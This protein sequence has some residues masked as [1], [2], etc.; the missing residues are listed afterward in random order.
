MAGRDLRVALEAIIGERRLLE[1]PFYRRWVRG[2]L[3]VDELRA[4]AGQYRHFEAHLPELLTTIA[5]GATDPG[6][7]A[8]ADR[9]LA[10]ETGGPAGHLGLFDDFLAGLGGTADPPSPATRHL[11]ET[12]DRHAA[13]S[14][15]A[16]LGAVL[17]YEWQSPEIAASKAAGLRE[18]HGL[19]GPAVTFWDVHAEVDGDHAAWLLEALAGSGE[20]AAVTAAATDACDAWL[21]FLD[22]R[23]A[24]APGARAIAAATA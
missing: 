15:A 1:H 18:H 5:G 20:P 13:A 9:N 22:E 12:Y 2:D 23:Q 14:A 11:L 7:R 16:G 6:L 10:D 17:A 4:Y 3:G 21:G 24:A 19:E 8:A